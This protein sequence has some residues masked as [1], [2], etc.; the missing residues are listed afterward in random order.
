[1]VMS[2]KREQFLNE[3]ERLLFDISREERD[4]AMTFYRS[5]FEDAGENNEENIIKELESPEKVAKSIRESLMEEEGATAEE[6]YGQNLAY[7][8]AEYYKNVNETIQNLQG[9]KKETNTAAIVLAIVLLVITSPIWLSLLATV[10]A[11]LVAVIAVVFALLFSGCAVAVAAIVTMVA[12]NPAAGFVVLGIAFLLLSIG[13]LAV[14]VMVWLFGKG[15]P[16]LCRG[17]GKLAKKI[18]GK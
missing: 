13:I 14:I 11:I 10:A 4:E 16:A 7:R 1:M 3:L 15:I 12:G 5:Y 9:K 17:I 6:R 18:A 8:N 2:M